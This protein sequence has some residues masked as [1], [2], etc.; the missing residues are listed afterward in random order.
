VE[1]CP[2][3]ARELAGRE[4]GVLE[5]VDLV[6]RDRPFF[7][8]SG[9]GVTFSGGEPLSQIQFLMACLEACRDRGL[10]TAVDT[11]GLAPREDLVGVAELADLLLFDLKHVDSD[12]HRS[13][14]GSGNRLI[15]DNL[16]CLSAGGTEIWIRVPLIP[17]VNDDAAHLDALGSFLATLARSH[18]VDLLPYHPIAESKTGRLGGARTFSSYPAPDAA[19]L[20][21]ARSRLRALGLEVVTGGSP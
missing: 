11:C 2:A 4:Y 16:K 6:E 19:T 20:D 13:Y 7:A 17:G 18:R 3:G 12:I 9:G 15:L 14:T 5:L 1:V 8:S 21:A 10:H